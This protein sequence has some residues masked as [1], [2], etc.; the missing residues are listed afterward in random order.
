MNL[1]HRLSFNCISFCAPTRL[2]PVLQRVSARRVLLPSKCNLRV[3]V[4]LITCVV[5]AATSQAVTGKEKAWAMFEAAGSKS[6]SEHAI[7]IRALG[8]LRG[9]AH[10]RELAEAALEDSKPE[11]RI[12]A[13]TA[14]GQMRAT[15]SIPKLQKLLSDDKLAVVMA[16]AHSLRELKDNS[17]AYAVYYD[18]LTGGRKADGLVSKQLD[19]LHDPKEMT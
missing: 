17:S 8:L 5:T 16:A 2:P 13:A 6:T 7:G 9:N 15:Q 4:V 3:T 11:G 1:S 10:A 18:V 12:A 19:T 14:L